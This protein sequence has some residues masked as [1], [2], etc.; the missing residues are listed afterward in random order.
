MYKD[1]LE[2]RMRL[3]QEILDTQN[4]IE[5]LCEQF[6]IPSSESSN[7]L[8][9][10]EYK[11][12]ID[13]DFIVSKTDIKGVITYANDTFCK[14]SKYKRKELIGKKHN[15]VKDPKNPPKLYE[16]MWKTI[17][18]KK[19]WKGSFSNRAKDGRLYYV[20]A[21]IKP[22]LNDNGDI[23]EYIAI[24]KNITKEVEAKHEIEEQKQFIQTIFDNQDNIVVYTSKTKG[25]LSVNKRLFEYLDFKNFKE[26][27]TK[28]QCICDLF[29]K[30]EGYIDP[31]TYPDWLDMAADSQKAYKALMKTKDGVLRTFSFTV[32]KFEKNYLINLNDITELENALLRAYQSEQAKSIFLANMSHEIRTPLNGIIGFTEMLMKKELDDE[33]R[34]YI[35]IIFNSGKSLLYIVNDILD[36]S[37]IQENKIELDLQEAD[38]FLE[39]EATVHTLASV[40]KTKH[41]EYFTYID[42]GLPHTVLC[43]V[44]KLKQVMTNLIGNAIKFTPQNGKVEVAVRLEEIQ[45]KKATIHFSVSDNG[46]GIPKEKIETIFQPFSQADGSTARKFGGTGLG[47]AIS[48][49]FVE[50]MGSQIKVDS[51][52]GKGS[53]FEFSITCDILDEQNALSM[54]SN[55]PLHILI[56][57][58]RDGSKISCAV[59]DS[60][61]EYLDAWGI[62][63][64]A[65]DRYE[66][67]EAQTDVLIVCEETFDAKTCR[68][69]LDRNEHLHILFIEGQGDG[70]FCT[71]ERFTQLPQPITGSLLFDAIIPHLQE[72]RGQTDSLSHSIE[73]FDAKVLVAEDNETNQILIGALL[74]E[75]G[76]TYK[77]VTNGQEAID[78][79]LSE[80][81]D[82]ILMDVNMPVLDGIEAIKRLK[83]KGYKPPIVTL[84]ADVIQSNVERFK[85]AGA[86]DTLP[87]PI[88][89]DLLDTVLRRYLKPKQKQSF[90]FDTI[91]IETIQKKMMIPNE[92]IIYRLLESFSESLTKTLKKLQN[93][94]AD[95]ATLHSLKGLIGNL[96]LENS[97]KFIVNCEA[98][99]Q[100]CSHTQLV[101]ILENLLEQTETI[102]SKHN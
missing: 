53:C 100:K 78:A 71:H 42:P 83:E 97:Y 85:A 63:Y 90:A 80:T 9:A 38:L 84:S 49:R 2:L 91:D 67:I 46:I 68:N 44:H 94:H 61:V 51:T 74:D 82:L 92:A 79:A 5:S 55:A 54:P 50:M 56:M 36:F 96:C 11:A 8:L 87:K 26:F 73:Q 35:E 65:I 57:K 7:N 31:I 1:E 19:T 37:K 60:I 64:K 72:K 101:A 70:S 81:F 23:V 24:R 69:I 18:A 102:L 15:I 89:T 95:G 58:R 48:S 3:A 14:V 66:N 4:D 6:Y 30:K 39:M 10:K 22:I 27:K 93:D 47:L 62:P 20:E 88:E 98:D 45:G 77:M 34:R 33:V 16:D 52:P 40:A 99:P 25:M 21:I 86:D 17:T 29:I 43:D 28:H 12:I 13:S 32:K 76:I 75:R 59:F 41:V